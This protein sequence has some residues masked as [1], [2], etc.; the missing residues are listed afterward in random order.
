MHR[1]F[2]TNWV[3]GT[4]DYT[5]RLQAVENEDIKVSNK[6]IKERRE[7]DVDDDLAREIQER[8]AL[9][10]KL[11]RDNL[12]L[13]Q[14]RTR[15]LSEYASSD[16]GS[17]TAIRERIGMEKL[18]EKVKDAVTVTDEMLEESFTKVKVRELVV[19][20]YRLE[21][22]SL[23]P[24]DEEQEELEGNI[25]EAKEKEEDPEPTWQER[26]DAIALE[27]RSVKSTDWDAE[28]QAMAEDLLKQINDGADFG[29]LAKENSTAYTAEEGGLR[30]DFTGRQEWM[31]NA[32]VW[33]AMLLLEPGGVSDVVKTGT[34]PYIS[35]YLVKV[36]EKKLELP[37][38]FEDEKETHRLDLEDGLKRQAWERYLRRMQ[39]EADIAIH[40]VEIQAYR[41]MDKTGDEDQAIELLEQAAP[42]DPHNAGL[43]YE[44]A[45]LYHERGESAR[46]LELAE[47]IVEIPGADRFAMFQVTYGDV[48]EEA[49]RVT[50]AVQAY[51]SA[52]DYA[53]GLEYQNQM[54]HQLL[55]M[56]LEDL[57]EE[58][59]VAEEMAW[60]ER[61]QE[62]Q[63]EMG[64]MGGG[65]LNVQ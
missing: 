16:A 14:Y 23:E 57:G 29:E 45:K 34:D 47:E 21:Q 26:I 1:S 49:G 15:K 36:E 32:E 5:L 51:K 50:E 12:T 37:E 48:L 6:E 13:D 63:A 33:E 38:K 17:D 58:E 9:A 60:M 64:G 41:L 44:L 18:E 42:N 52:H 7:Q 11:E 55:M 40:D 30:E 28:A 54:V 56:R 3:E 53:V 10:K 31:W 19:S 61:F 59:L 20:P 4:I 46:A 62:A 43:R 8:T 24:L 39:E 65:M 35:Y 2:V 25:D 27:R 22:E